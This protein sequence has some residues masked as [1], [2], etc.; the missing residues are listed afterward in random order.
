MVH[1]RLQS[2]AAV[3]EVVDDYRMRYPGIMSMSLFFVIA[4]IVVHILGGFW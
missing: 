1:Y 3:R 2:L 4:A